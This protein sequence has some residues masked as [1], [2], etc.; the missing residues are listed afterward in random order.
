MPLPQRPSMRSR[1]LLPS[2][3]AHSA[4]KRPRRAVGDGATVTAPMRTAGRPAHCSDGSGREPGRNLRAACRP[5]GGIDRMLTPDYSLQKIITTGED[6]QREDSLLSTQALGLG[7]GR[8]RARRSRTTR[9]GRGTWRSTNTL[10]LV[11]FPETAAEV[12]IA[13]PGSRSRTASAWRHRGPATEPVRWAPSVSDP[14]SDLAAGLHSPSTGSHRATSARESPGPGSKRR[15][16]SPAWPGSPAR[17]PT[18]AWSDTRSVAASAGW[19]D[20]RPRLQQR[21]VDSK[22]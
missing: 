8:C 22:S 20:L 12:V 16:P 17:R 15:P 11:V 4:G 9:A 6:A 18:W 21:P 13:R 1:R 19:P 14:S 3:T 7:A 2:R 10:R 5:D